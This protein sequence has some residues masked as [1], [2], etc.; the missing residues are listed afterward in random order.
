MIVRVTPA[1][2]RKG[3]ILPFAAFLLVVV[4]GMVAFAVDIG[5]I[6]M[7]RTELQAAADAAALAGADP[8]MDAYVQYEMAGTSGASG[9]SQSTILTNAMKA[10]RAKA[11]KWASYNGAGGVSSLTLNSGDVQFGYTDGSYNYTPYTSGGPFPNTVKVTMRMD[12]SANGALGLFFAP[13]IG[14]GSTNLK[15]T[16]AAVIMGGKVNNFSS[17][18]GNIAVLPVTYDVNWW[19]NFLQTGK[20]PDGTSS[21]DSNGI[22]Q[23]QVYPCIQDVGNFGV[24]SLDDSHIGASTV[25]GWIQ[26]GMAPSDLKALQTAGLVPLSS[27]PNEWDW[28][29][30]TGFKSSDVQA[31]NNCIGTTFVLPLFTPYATESSPG[32]YQAGVGTGSGYAYNIVQFVGV[33]I[34]TPPSSN[35]QVY[36]Q[37]AAVVNPAAAFSSVAPVDTTQGSSGLV[38]TF[39]YP[40][41]VQ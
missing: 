10:A 37:P 23:L 22:P 18:G 14:N 15:A 3:A 40:R 20:W 6:V 12:S 28:S 26:D 19:N 31:M 9:A 21:T 27:H 38:T 32:G 25:D 1:P 13:V 41:L 39:T 5:W 30:D 8:L 2:C 16:A 36:I 35:Q 33:K 29:G 7:S 4:L 17:A 34:V 24:L 11:I